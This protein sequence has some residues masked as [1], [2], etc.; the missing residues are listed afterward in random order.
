MSEASR[1]ALVR[2]IFSR[3]FSFSSNASNQGAVLLIERSAHRLLP[4]WPWLRLTEPE[5]SLVTWLIWPRETRGVVKT[6]ASVIA[7]K[8]D[9][10]MG[11]Q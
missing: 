9:E 6:V 5:L 10:A 7:S 1:W 2:P 3:S 11:P 8:N 4:D